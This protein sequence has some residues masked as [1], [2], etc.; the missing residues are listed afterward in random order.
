MFFL[1]IDFSTVLPAALLGM[2]LALV[3][4][5]LLLCILH[6]CGFRVLWSIKKTLH[7]E[8]SKDLITVAEAP[9]ESEIS[10]EELIVILTAAATAALGDT[11][12]KRFRVVA[13]RRI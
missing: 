11:G 12:T 8:K 4:I 5:A 7:R 3:T 1:S 6:L 13:F 2:L 10:E 9:E